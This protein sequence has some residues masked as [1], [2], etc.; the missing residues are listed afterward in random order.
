MAVTPDQVYGDSEW[1]RSNPALISK[2]SQIL[3]SSGIVPDAQTLQRYGL[4]G[5]FDPSVS[6][7]ATNNPYSTAALLRGQ[8]K[9]NLTNNGTNAN[10]HGM[11]FSG[12]FQNTQDQAGSDYQKAYSQA[13]TDELNS[14]M[15]VQ[16]QQNDLYN[17]VFGRLLSQ[18]VAPDPA[19]YSNPGGSEADRPGNQTNPWHVP[20][21]LGQD[22]TAPIKRKKPKPVTFA[23][24]LAPGRF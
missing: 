4:S 10:A 1:L 24:V 9:T 23:P 22:V 5:L 11:L 17:S 8:L 20:N 14:L 12:A 18:P 2:F 19:V 13:G 15:G 21:T 16:G 6:A 3:L 7:G